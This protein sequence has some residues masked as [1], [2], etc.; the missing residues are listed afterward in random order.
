MI[1]GELVAGCGNAQNRGCEE[2]GGTTCQQSHCS[3]PQREHSAQDD[4]PVPRWVLETPE[5]WGGGFEAKA[6]FG[7]TALLLTQVDDSAILL[8]AVGSISQDE[9]VPQTDRCRQGN[10]TTV[11]TKHD[12]ARG[13]YEWSFVGQRAL[14]DHR[15]LCRHS[16]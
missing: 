2:A 3:C 7:P 4:A 5:L 9:P 10:K 6:N 1:R 13:I 12:S 15:Q 16:L 8:L 11:S 14:R